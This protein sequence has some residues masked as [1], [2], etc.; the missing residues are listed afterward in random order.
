M[1]TDQECWDILRE[2]SFELHSHLKGAN[3]ARIAQKRGYALEGEE[4][5]PRSEA[6]TRV[7]NDVIDIVIM[8]L[9]EATKAFEAWYAKFREQYMGKV[10]LW[11][12]KGP[13]GNELWRMAVEVRLTTY[14]ITIPTNRY[15]NW[16]WHPSYNTRHVKEA[17][18]LDLNLRLPSSPLR[19]QFLTGD[20]E[21]YSE[22]HSFSR[23]AML[24]PQERHLQVHVT[25]F[26][27]GITHDLDDDE[28]ICQNI[29]ELHETTPE[30]IMALLQEQ[31]TKVQK[32]LISK[33]AEADFGHTRGAL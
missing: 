31:Q 5:A 11:I 13:N 8:P 9:V 17:S 19:Y 3:L 24:N 30:E 18:P 7:L 28:P 27:G 14:A 22:F 6:V 26:F 1:R 10:F 25:D 33:M 20:F 4:V 32:N 29:Q 15:S 16:F 23:N 21:A 2:R 12:R